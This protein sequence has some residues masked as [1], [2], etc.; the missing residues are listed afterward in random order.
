MSNVSISHGQEEYADSTNRN[1][2]ISLKFGNGNFECGF[3]KIKLSTVVGDKKKSTDLEIQLSAAPLI[4]QHYQ[5]WQD[6]YSKL[7]GTQVRKILP[8][9]TS[10]SIDIEG[11]IRGGFKEQQSTNFSFVEI[12]QQCNQDAEDLRYQ[13]NQWFTVIKSHLE[14][15]LDFCSSLNTSSNTSSNT[16]INLNTSSNSNSNI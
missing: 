3:E 14:A 2:V 9:Q 10:S 4:P 5:S 7:V 11:F 6:K 1:L 13:I 15:N 16:N 12:Q 8:Q